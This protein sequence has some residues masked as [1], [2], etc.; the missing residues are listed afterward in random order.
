MVAATDTT[1][2][3]LTADAVLVL[4]VVINAI[5]GWR[6][7]TL[8]RVLAFAGLYVGVLGAYYLGNGFAGWVRK[9]DIIANGWSFVAITAVVV[10]MF[11]VIGRLVAY[12]IERIAALAFDRVA[13]VLIGGAVG[14]FQAGVLFMVALAVGAAPVAQGTTIPANRD[15]AANAIRAA[16]LAGQAVRAQPAVRAI[17]APV[18][19][20]S[21]TTH[22]EEGTQLTT[23]R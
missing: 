18:P 22:L 17:F 21:L 1:V 23:P 13:G 15:A 20:D 6:T 8:R 2:Q 16:A 14:F 4:L 9:G 12:R 3:Q 10:I 11:E 5:A 19:L 7:G